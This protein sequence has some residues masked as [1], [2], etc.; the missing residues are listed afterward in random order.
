MNP[1]EHTHLSQSAQLA[2]S[3]NRG[4]MVALPW[5]S[6]RHGLSLLMQGV[7]K[8]SSKTS[9]PWQQMA[10]ERRR[11]LMLLVALTTATVAYL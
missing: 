8:Q 9:Y 10:I 5:T 4:S 11:V 3:I 2:P 6:F 7:N 1:N